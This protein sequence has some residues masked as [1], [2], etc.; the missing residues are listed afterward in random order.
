MEDVL[1][2]INQ[3]PRVWQY[4]PHMVNIV[5]EWREKVLL[6]WCH[7]SSS[8]TVV[9]AARTTLVLPVEVAASRVQ[10]RVRAPN[11]HHLPRARLPSTNERLL[12]RFHIYIRTT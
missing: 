6:L 8:Y 9:T 12:W 2:G 7:S 10:L 4:I 3:I 11:E 5:Q 1:C